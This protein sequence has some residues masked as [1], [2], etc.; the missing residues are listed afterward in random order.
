MTNGPRDLALRTGPRDL[1]QKVLD[2]GL[3]TLCGACLGLC[4]HLAV[5]RDRVVRSFDCGRETGR[6][7]AV[8]PVAAVREAPL[9]DAAGAPLG[10]VRSASWSRAGNADVRAVGQYGGTVSALL[11]HLLETGRVAA[12]RVAG[13]PSSPAFPLRPSATWARN[14]EEVLAAAGTRYVPRPGAEMRPGTWPE[15]VAFVGRP[16]EI[17]GLRRRLEVDPE[18]A[19][20]AIFIGLLCTWAL[21]HDLLVA[22]LRRHLDPAETWTME[23]G[24]ENLLVV[25]TQGSPLTFPLSEIR[26]LAREACRACADFS[27]EAADVSVGSTEDDPTWNSLLVRTE[28]GEAVVEAAVAAGALEVRPM[29]AE[30]LEALE[31]AAARARARAAEVL[32]DLG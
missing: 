12:A 32:H 30:R 27:A 5:G 1:A 20:V 15:P 25:R 2:P 29:P 31:V 16:C 21:D 26:L 13:P 28:A 23:M 10:Q 4:P 8:C 14:R 24:R 7:Y 6:C 18:A 17:R 9:P 19:S 3:C 11:V 22:Y